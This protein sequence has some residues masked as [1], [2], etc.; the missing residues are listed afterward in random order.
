MVLKPQT[1]R[2]WK[3]FTGLA[4]GATAFHTVFRVDY[5]PHDHCF[6]GIQKWYGERVDAFLGIGSNS[7]VLPPLPKATAAA[8]AA[9]AEGARDRPRSPTNDEPAGVR[10]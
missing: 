5:G 8:A 2:N 6:T 10:R 3:I 4:T 7:E 9:A 1:L